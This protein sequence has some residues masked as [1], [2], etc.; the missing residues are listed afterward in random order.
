MLEFWPEAVISI[1]S[2]LGDDSETFMGFIESQDLK[3]LREENIVLEFWPHCLDPI[4]N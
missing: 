3:L 2:L 4:P 1:F